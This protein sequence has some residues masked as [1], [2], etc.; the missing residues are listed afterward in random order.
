[1]QGRNEV[2]IAALVLLGAL[3]FA[4]YR[5]GLLRLPAA[6]KPGVKT[7]MVPPTG[8]LDLETGE[9]GTPKADLQ[10]A[11]AAPGRPALHPLLGALIA[12]GGSVRWE[13]IGAVYLAGLRYSAAWHAASGPEATMRP[14]EV[15]AVRTGEGNLAKIR[16]AEIRGNFDLQLEW[17]LYAPPPGAAAPSPAAAAVPA[18]AAPATPESPNPSLAWRALREEALAAYR[19]KRYD[20]ALQAC[21]L[22]IAAA[23][24]AGG[25]AHVAAL[26]GCGG[27]LGLHR[28]AP[29]KIEG[30][31][32]QAVALA[33]PLAPE[34]IEAVLGPGEALLK[35]RCRR[36]LGVFYRDQ[37][38]PREAATQFALAI[39]AV[40]AFAPP[41]TG[42]HRLALRSDLF[43]LGMLLAQLGYGETARRALAE[44]RE[45]YLKTE[46]QHSALTAI[47]EQERRLGVQERPLGAAPSR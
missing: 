28:H 13:H 4:G 43:D 26:A 17:V 33:E 38:R 25:V 15:F 18:A 6:D 27:L 21:D 45:Y 11:L 2:V 32:K 31:L 41:E 7:A 12:P 9:Q 44:S 20:D 36:M 37:N 42:E 30:W 39:E 47:E 34:A 22:A 16:V 29:Q 23:R 8:T 5:S 1:M 46:P 10:W 3:L 40:R 14:G 19:A 24:D 35:Q